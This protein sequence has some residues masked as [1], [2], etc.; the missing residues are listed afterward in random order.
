MKLT[1]RLYRAAAPIWAGYHTH[2]FVTGMGDGTL[3]PNKFRFFLL[4]DYVY[5]FDYAR[6]FALGIVKAG[7]PDLMRRFARNVDEAL[8]GEMSIHRAYMKRLGISEAQAARAKPALANRSY[9]NYMLSVAYAGGPAEITA[10]ILACSWSYA[11]IGA[12]LARRP[13]AAQHPL[14]GEWISGYAGA[15]YQAANVDLIS[16]MDELAEDCSETQMDY[17]ADIFVTCSRYEAG[18]W[19]MAWNREM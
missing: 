13:G 15:E 10:A 18:F 6:V 8:D 5:L 4:Q 2:P 17:L 19:D 3:D 1:D 16:L 7:N 11:E 14:F 12:K 9:T